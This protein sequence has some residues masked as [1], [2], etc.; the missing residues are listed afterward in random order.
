MAEHADFK[1]RMAE[2]M[3]SGANGLDALEK[4]NL[5]AAERTLV[6]SWVAASKWLYDCDTRPEERKVLET[7][8]RNLL[9]LL[10]TT[11]SQ[12]GAGLRHQRKFL[13]AV[14]YALRAAKRHR[15]LNE[16]RRTALVL[17]NAANAYME[18]RRFDRAEPLYRGCLDTFESLN[19]D[20]KVAEVRSTMQQIR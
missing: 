1:S 4:G 5:T 9:H 7:N 3:E 14:K 16:Y 17:E 12:I 19:D 20:A 18:M 10:A 2:L 15:Q 6:S 13:D 8:R 11:E